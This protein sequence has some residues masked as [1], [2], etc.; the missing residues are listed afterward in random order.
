MLAKKLSYGF[1]DIDQIVEKVAKKSI[2]EIFELEGEIGF[3]ELETKV[4]KEIGKRY[5]LVVSTGGGIVTRTE[6]WGIL[7][8]GLVTWIDPKR[9]I[10]LSRL[11]SDKSVR[12]MLGNDLITKFDTLLSGFPAVR[13]F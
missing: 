8:Q 12:P 11:H 9:E 10:V 4:L 1:V 13:R 3:R 5:S 7:H 2:K 6:N